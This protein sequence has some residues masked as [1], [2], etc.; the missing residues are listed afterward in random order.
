[1]AKNRE[2]R[3][4]RCLRCGRQVELEFEQPFCDVHRTGRVTVVHLGYAS[5]PCSRVFVHNRDCTIITS[6]TRT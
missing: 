4:G 6:L 1:M 3:W 5:L 2:A